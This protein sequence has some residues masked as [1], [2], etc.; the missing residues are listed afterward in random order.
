MR[1]LPL[2]GLIAAVLLASGCS[3]R[4]TV[5]ELATAPP[6]PDPVP[7]TTANPATDA[8]I[9]NGLAAA[10]GAE[11][12]FPPPLL[13][14]VGPAAGPP[15]NVLVLSGGG[16]YTA[17][18]VGNLVGWTKSGTRP[19]FDVAT[20]ISSGA[21]AAGFAFLGPKYDGRMTTQYT[22]LSRKDLFTINPVRNLLRTQSLAS[23]APLQKRIET[24]VD[25]GFMAD[26]RQAHSEG[27]RLYV[28]T[29]QLKA[30]RL[31][32]WDLGAV[33]C[34]GRPDAT[35]LVHKIFLAASSIPG[36]SPPVEFDVEVNGCRYAERHSDGGTHTE[37]FVQTPAG[38]PPGSNVYV[39]TA[40]KFY[41][42]P[43]PDNAG[44]LTLYYSN[45]TCSLSA[46]YRAD[47]MKIYTLCA[48]S[49]AKFRTVAMPQDFPV[50]PSSLVFT[51]EETQRLF[52]LGY[53]ATACGTP[54]RN[55][56]PGVP[57]DERPPVRNGGY[58]RVR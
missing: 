11:A 42:D 1:G 32:I 40:G 51:P 41:P 22:T 18:N 50:K 14:G 5:T 37:G 19:V 8:V 52:D 47:L 21:L 34:C 55:T 20:G 58:P 10:L 25:E 35:R 16:K 31:V 24:E 15:L 2:T 6:W 7:P 13:A 3:G 9:V 4:S 54:W 45:V 26:L 23:S 12:P 36:F 46:L 49:H 53:K 38:L 30:Q 29:N 48:V 17:Y 39:L 27:R 56:P 28:A 43:L 57:D 44:F 33:A